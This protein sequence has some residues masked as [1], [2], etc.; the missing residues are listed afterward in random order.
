LAP[1]EN[2][3]II[4]DEEA[5]GAMTSLPAEPIEPQPPQNPDRPQQ[6]P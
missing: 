5:S 2:P 3:P 4:G 1:T 6:N